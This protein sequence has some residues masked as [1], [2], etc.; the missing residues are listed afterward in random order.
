MMMIL[1]MMMRET[2]KEKKREHSFLREYLSCTEYSDYCSTFDEKR[3]PVL[4]I[5][6][7]KDLH[8]DHCPPP[9]TPYE[10]P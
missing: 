8:I 2:Q 4:R 9:H 3:E 6:R 10:D 1:T 5:D 7:I